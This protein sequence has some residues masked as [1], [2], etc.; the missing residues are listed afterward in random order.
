MKT[1]LYFIE[2]KY[3]A[4]GESETGAEYVCVTPFGLLRMCDKFDEMFYNE[5]LKEYLNFYDEYNYVRVL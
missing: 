2:Y 4:D 5:S 3:T 1:G